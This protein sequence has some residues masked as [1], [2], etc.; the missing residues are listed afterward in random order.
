MK[1][2]L[3]NINIKISGPVLIIIAAALWAF[4]GVIRRSLYVLNPLHIVF[5]EHLVGA[6]ILLPIGIVFLSQTKLTK[7]D[8]GLVVLVSLL[9]GLLGTLFFTTALLKTNYISFSVVFLLQKL[10]PI[11]AIST[12]AIFLKEKFNRSYIIYGGLALVA[13]YFVTFP[14]GQINFVTGSA[15]AIAA[16]FAFLAAVAWGSSTTFSKMLLVEHNSTLITALRFWVTTALAFIAIGLTGTLGILHLPNFPQTIKFVIIALSTGMVALLI[17]YRGL[18]TTP[19]RVSTILEL[20]FPFLAVFID[21]VFY[22]SVLAVSQYLAAL[23]LL[24]A[25]YKMTALQNQHEI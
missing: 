15:T 23:V 17:Y 18:R 8:W 22:H 4:D 2:F 7:K 6:L 11:F 20:T 21:V 14:N 19:V 1:T 12:A 24:Y 9:S 13:A 16:L 5:F 25:M 10:Q 3:D